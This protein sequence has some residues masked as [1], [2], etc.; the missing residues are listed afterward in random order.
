MQTRFEFDRMTTEPSIVSSE[1]HGAI[2]VTA[3]ENL[4]I[5][6]LPAFTAQQRALLDQFFELNQRYKDSLHQAEES[7]TMSLTT[8]RQNRM[9][10][11][12]ITDVAC[13]RR[14]FFETV[15][16]ILSS[17]VTIGYEMA[18]HDHTTHRKRSWDLDALLRV[19]PDQVAN[20]DLVETISYPQEKIRLRRHYVV[21]NQHLYWRTNQVTHHQQVV[22]WT[23]GLMLL[24][25][26]LEPHSIWLAHHFLSV[27]AYT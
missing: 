22:P 12:D 7:L 1:K 17:T 14:E 23:E 3:T 6:Q 13:F 2:P 8:Y 25:K 27:Q 5:P 19:K 4:Q 20:G 21:Q 15:H 26:F 16:V 18:F 11:G 9:C 24:Q 10:Y